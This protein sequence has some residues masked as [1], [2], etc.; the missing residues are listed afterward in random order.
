[1]PAKKISAPKKKQKGTAKKQSARTLLPS[2]TEDEERK[3]RVKFL[4][5]YEHQR[6]MLEL[7]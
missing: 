3:L 2:W 6:D 4:Q 5:K 7:L 1:M